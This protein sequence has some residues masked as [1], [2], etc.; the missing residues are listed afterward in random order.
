LESGRL[1]KLHRALSTRSL[2]RR[3]TQRLLDYLRTADS[4]TY[5]ANEAAECEKKINESGALET[6]TI[7]LSVSPHKLMLEHLERSGQS[8][9]GD[10]ETYARESG[11]NSLAELSVALERNRLGE[12]DG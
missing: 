8:V 6:M 11:F 7:D 9:D 2:H 1:R 3:G 4:Y 12:T 10:L 5:W